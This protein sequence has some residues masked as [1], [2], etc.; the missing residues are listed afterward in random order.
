MV[1]I[2]VEIPYDTIISVFH[3]CFDFAG[4]VYPGV[5]DIPLRSG[6]PL[7]PHS[8]D[9]GAGPVVSFHSDLM[10]C[11]RLISSA[12]VENTQFAHPPLSDPLTH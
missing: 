8:C 9:I 6:H 1:G 2:N 11:S 10:G 3:A 7:D 12:G 5:P 4:N